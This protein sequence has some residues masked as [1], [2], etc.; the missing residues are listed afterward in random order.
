MPPRRGTTPAGAITAGPAKTGQDFHSYC[1][2]SPHLQGLW[3]HRP[4]SLTPPSPQHLAV[5]AAQPWSA[6]STH[7][8]EEHNPKQPPPSAASSL[9][10]PRAWTKITTVVITHSRGHPRYD[11]NPS[12]PDRNRA[13]TDLTRPSPSRST[14][15]GRHHRTHQ[16]RGGRPPAA[17]QEILP[18]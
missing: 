14:P 6:D 2:T 17:R 5:E 12:S 1:Y 11:P 4:C 13:V 18:G 15:M 3:P 10:S 8:R 7:S 9:P 16:F